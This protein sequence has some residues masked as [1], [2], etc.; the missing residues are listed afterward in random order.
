MTCELRDQGRDLS[1]G[2]QP[3]LGAYKGFS[4]QVWLLTAGTLVVFS[5]QM[6]TRSAALYLSVA[7]DIPVIE[8][9]GIVSAAGIG[10][11]TGAAIAP[12][13][14]ARFGNARTCLFTQLIACLAP[15]SII[16]MKSGVPIAVALAV[17]GFCRAVFRPTYNA[18]VLDA[19]G[20]SNRT[21]AYSLYITA[22]NIGSGFSALLT[23]YL[24]SLH[25]VYIPT[26]E[27]ITGMIGVIIIS[28]AFGRT[29]RHDV[30]VPSAKAQTNVKLTA[31]AICICIVY[32]LSEVVTYQTHVTVPIFLLDQYHL[33]TFQIGFLN[34]LM[35]WPVA[36][37]SLPVTHLMRRFDQ[38]HVAA[39]AMFLIG[40][41]FLAFTFGSGFFL[42]IASRALYLMGSILLYPALVFLLL[43]GSP[44]A[45]KSRYLAVYYMMSTVAG[46]VAPFGGGAIMSRL[47]PQTLWLCCFTVSLIS[48]GVILGAANT[49]G[50][51][52]LARPDSAG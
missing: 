38:F 1:L 37:L 10:G 19:A 46:L 41:S 36:V 39:A 25:S 49:V 16:F 30:K 52:K 47:S 27:A 43:L 6:L 5:G 20:E 18:I 32:L 29:G 48:I 7:T 3:K 31:V 35:T 14:A 50:D 4:P 44:E 11:I 26:A 17:I 12:W 34:L 8:I 40:F 23:G 45:A 21:H 15:L 51:R 9:G 13:V 24:L 2:A 28:V 42:S 33:T 22:S